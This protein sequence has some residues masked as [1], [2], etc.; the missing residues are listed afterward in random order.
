MKM[1]GLFR[2]K[3]QKDDTAAR[4]KLKD[5][6][7]EEAPAEAEEAEETEDEETAEDAGVGVGNLKE[8]SEI[9]G[10]LEEVEDKLGRIDSALT[11]LR[12]DTA[13][14]KDRMNQSEQDM[15]KLLSVYEIVSAKFNPFIDVSDKAPEKVAPQTLSAE[16]LELPPISIGGIC[17]SSNRTRKGS[18]R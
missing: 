4:R 6:E 1:V 16:G 8:M 11:M 18:P 7:E 15:R 13:Q 9:L 12:N 10:R 2:K 5:F 3:P 17:P 14:V